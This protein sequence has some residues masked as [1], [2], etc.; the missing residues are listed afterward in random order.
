MSTSFARDI[1]PVLA[2]YRDNMTWRLDLTEY[3]AVKANAD[4]IYSKISAA[5]GTPMPPPPL[6]PLRL[7]DVAMFNAWM[8]DG[9]PP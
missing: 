9:C 4:H 6:P 1:A 5:D 8:T 2:P 3:E 7:S